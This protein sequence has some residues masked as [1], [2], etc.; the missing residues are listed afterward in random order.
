LRIRRP[1][2]AL[3]SCS[4]T[5]EISPTSTPA[6]STVWPWPGVTAC[7]VDISASTL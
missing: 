3:P 2:I 5:L 1:T 6:M 7:A 4:L